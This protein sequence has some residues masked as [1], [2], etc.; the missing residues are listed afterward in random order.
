MDT[1]HDNEFAISR[2]TGEFANPATETRF[3]IETREEWLGQLQVSLVVG[4]AFYLMF[5][6]TDLL[7]LGY[8]DVFLILLSARAIAAA[9]ILTPLVLARSG[10]SF[11][12][13]DRSLLVGAIIIGLIYGFIIVVRDE[14]TVFHALTLM[15][16]V[17]VVYL[18][19]PNRY[20]FTVASGIGISIA[21]FVLSVVWLPLTSRNL[22]S[23]VLLL[24]LCNVLGVIMGQ[25]IRRMRRGEYT[26]NR[27][28]RREMEE[29]IKMEIAAQHGEE[30]FRRLFDATPFPLM[31]FQTSDGKLVRANR[32]ADDLLGSLSSA[33]FA[34]KDLPAG[35]KSDA[36]LSAMNN[37]GQLAGLEAK[38]DLPG[39][40]IRDALLSGNTVVYDGIPCYLIGA[41][42]ISE[43]KKSEEELRQAKTEAE[44]A[45][46]AKSQFLAHMSH[47]LRTPLNSVIGFSDILTNEIFGSL[48]DARYKDYSRDINES[49]RHLLSLI[50]DIL[51]ISRIEAGASDLSES[52]IDIGK[53][54][55]DC[56]RLI[57][58]RAQS[59]G[60]IYK[61]HVDEATPK[62]LADER[63]VKQILLNILG[64]AIK[65]T[66]RGGEIAVTGGLLPDGRI[67]I[68][69]RDSGIGIDEKDMTRIIQPFAQIGNVMTKSHDGTGLGLWLTKNLV[70]LHGGELNIGSARNKGTTVTVTFPAERT[71]K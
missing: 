71:V 31:L 7:Y 64:N 67:T 19:V 16:I 18:F 25:R 62:L 68:E 15:M 57:R 11:P 61:E 1:L 13:V 14:G 43:R 69:I 22:T 37:K 36:L 49:G 29:R 38:I 55:D 63:R 10:F 34:L 40:R 2:L 66:P 5:A 32:A 60:I 50:N 9:A 8:G 26:Q 27:V 3:R 70:D 39:A 47:E 30:N 17:I 44:F 35:D 24:L 51:D 28:L 53:A 33:H 45:S 46:T 6:I 52:N 58:E 42:D 56:G 21:Y 48:G 4:A 20:F 41:T 12:V 54:I 59:C 65:F 23:I